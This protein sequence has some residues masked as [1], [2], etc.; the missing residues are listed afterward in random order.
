MTAQLQH[1]SAE[2]AGRMLRFFPVARIS[3][4]LPSPINHPVLRAT[5]EVATAALGLIGIGYALYNRPITWSQATLSMALLGGGSVMTLLGIASHKHGEAIRAHRLFLLQSLRHHSTMEAFYRAASQLSH[6]KDQEGLD[7]L[8]E[9][10]PQLKN[11][12]NK[13]RDNFLAYVILQGDV[14][15]TRDLLSRPCFPPERALN[16]VSIYTD[17]TPL[18]HALYQLNIPLAKLLLEKGASLSLLPNPR[19]RPAIEGIFLSPKWESQ[20]PLSTQD[21]RVLKRMLVTHG[22][23]SFNLGLTSK[24][25]SPMT[26]K[27]LLRSTIEGVKGSDLQ[28]LKQSQRFALL[29]WLFCEEPAFQKQ[30]HHAIHFYAPEDLTT[31]F[32]GGYLSGKIPQEKQDKIRDLKEAFKKGNNLY[33]SA[34]CLG[35]LSA[36]TLAPHEEFSLFGQPTSLL[37]IAIE[38]DLED[39]YNYLLDKVGIN[40]NQVV[41]PSNQESVVPLALAIQEGSLQAVNKLLSVPEIDLAPIEI[42]QNELGELIEDQ[43][44]PVFEMLMSHQR[45]QP[46]QEVLRAALSQ[47]AYQEASFTRVD[48][49]RSFFSDPRVKVNLPI[50]AGQ[51]E[52]QNM[53]SFLA[54][55]ASVGSLTDDMIIVNLLQERPEVEVSEEGLELLCKKQCSLTIGY[56]LNLGKISPN[57]QLPSK[58]LGLLEYFV[59]QY[60]RSGGEHK[61]LPAMICSFLMHPD[62]QAKL[63]LSIGEAADQLGMQFRDPREREAFEQ[64]YQQFTKKA[65]EARRYL[66][67]LV[68]QARKRKSNFTSLCDKVDKDPI[69]REM[70]VAAENRLPKLP[71]HVEDEIF[72]KGVGA[73]NL[74]MF[75][76]PKGET[77]QLPSIKEAWDLS[78]WGQSDE[79]DVLQHCRTCMM[80]I[81][82]DVYGRE[83]ELSAIEKNCQ[84]LFTVILDK[85]Y[86][87]GFPNPNDNPKQFDTVLSSLRQTLALIMEADEELCHK[88]RIGEN[89][90]QA[91]DLRQTIYNMLADIGKDCGSDMQQNLLAVLQMLQNTHLTCSQCWEKQVSI[92]VDMETSLERRMQKEIGRLLEPLRESVLEDLFYHLYNKYFKEL[93]YVDQEGVLVPDMVHLKTSFLKWVKEPMGLREDVDGYD[94]TVQSLPSYAA[95]LYEGQVEIGEDMRDIQNLFQKF[96]EQKKPEL[97]A[98]LNNEVRKQ[99]NTELY[100]SNEHLLVDAL[101]AY[102][103]RQHLE[104]AEF[105]Y[106]VMD[107]NDEMTVIERVRN[108]YLLKI[109][110]EYNVI[111][112]RKFL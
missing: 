69:F 45:F 104:P 107:M 67:K 56:L 57:E 55:T 76:Y 3:N 5:A 74:L 64:K 2:P 99:L 20:Q 111:C 93:E 110:K 75:P 78:V 60:A 21:M 100:G 18:G 108:R 106:R 73:F 79:Q 58:Q 86:L 23:H 19:G 40:V 36:E 112:G 32:A 70:L 81:V 43:G 15:L 94:P 88:I 101:S 52:H 27:T 92:P 33:S 44:Y 39:V 14:Q 54:H 29:E 48:Q 85:I 26:L 30:I 103:A 71:P 98:L 8:L 82:K 80:G 47:L 35:V 84:N 25:I 89:V 50:S 51:Q 83:E 109:L 87:H 97:L 12:Q 1:L 10:F 62:Y 17:M 68:K 9:T 61:R 63:H 49:Y 11:Y 34:F 72:T 6:L 53:L 42:Y 7:Q 102:A 41:T 46:S 77:L 13:S 105:L 31:S 95:V 24:T 22:K 90:E 37:S 91:K 28:S 16:Q 65:K 96:L 38:Y 66:P 4:L 59:L